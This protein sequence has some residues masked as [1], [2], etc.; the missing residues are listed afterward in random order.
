MYT[1]IT[2]DDTTQNTDR[3]HIL[4][5]TIVWIMQ[6]SYLY[7]ELTTRTNI[8]EARPRGSDVD[9]DVISCAIRNTSSLLGVDCLL[10]SLVK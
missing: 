9:S 10:N 2:C 7:E 4:C 6:I 5:I 3:E 8:E 1:T